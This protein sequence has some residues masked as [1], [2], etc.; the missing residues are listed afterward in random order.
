MEHGPTCIHED[1]TDELAAPFHIYSISTLTLRW[2]KI[3]GLR[4]ISN[5]VIP[6][7]STF[8]HGVPQQEKNIEKKVYPEFLNG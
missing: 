4:V 1:I 6:V 8:L 3:S 5:A 2:L 7:I